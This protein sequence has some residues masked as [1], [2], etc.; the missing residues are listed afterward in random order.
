MNKRLL[1]AAREVLRT[2]DTSGVAY[3]DDEC[4][5]AL[6]DVIQAID[7]TPQRV[8]A[9]AQRV[10]QRIADQIDGYDRDDLGES[11]DHPSTTKGTK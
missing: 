2:I 5:N 10:C 6:R 11:P 8:R 4:V 1:S 3:R 7:T 9:A